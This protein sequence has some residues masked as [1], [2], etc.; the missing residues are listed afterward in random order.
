MKKL[1]I[2]ICCALLA[3]CSSANAPKDEKKETKKHLRIQ[4][5][6]LSV[7]EII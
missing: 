3:G 1:W 6:P 7:L 5:Y 2:L 4:L